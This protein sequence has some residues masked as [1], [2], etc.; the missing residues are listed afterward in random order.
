L[1][2]LVKVTSFSLR[3]FSAHPIVPNMNRDGPEEGSD[4]LSMD[5]VK[6]GMVE[7]VR[8]GTFQTNKTYGS[9]SGEAYLN[10][11]HDGLNFVA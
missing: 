5:F 3:A 11:H 6:P 4:P 1:N 10:L 2:A 8:L 9:K 7:V